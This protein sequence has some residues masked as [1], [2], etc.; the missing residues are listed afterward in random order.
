MDKSPILRAMEELETMK[1]IL[2]KN[3][4]SPKRDSFHNSDNSK[5]VKS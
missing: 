5:Q 1:P 3:N 2:N 4:I